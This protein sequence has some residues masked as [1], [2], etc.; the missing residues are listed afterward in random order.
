MDYINKKN[1]T[2]NETLALAFENHKKNN[3]KAA[4]N[5]Y[6]KILN[7][8]PNHFESNFF[9]GTLLTQSRRFD[10]AQKLLAKA[11]QIKPDHADAHNNLGSV[12]KGLGKIQE[13]KI[14]FQKS[15]QIN[16]EAADVHYNLGVVFK[17][18]G[19]DMEA[20]ACYQKAI[21]KDH[22]HTVSLINLSELLKT[23]ELKMTTGTN[24]DHLKDLFLLLFRRNDVRHRDIF[25]KTRMLLKSEKN[26]HKIW[27]EIDLNSL[28]FKNK[29]IKNLL[30]EELFLLMLQK[31]LIADNFLEKILTKLRSDALFSFIDSDKN[32][33][34]ENL[35]FI[36]SLAEQCFL[37]EYVYTQTA[38]E[39]NFINQLKN[40]VENNTKINEMEII[41]LGCYIP[42]Y[43]SSGITNRL[44]NYKSKNTLFNDL[45]TM[46]IIEPLKE[47]KLVNSI[48]SFGE[49]SNVISKKV[50]DQYEKHPYP[51]WR[52]TY[53]NVRNNFLFFLN[54][55]IK[56]NK[57]LVKNKFTNPNVLVAGCGTGNHM[58][59]VENYSNANILAVDLSL[60]SLAYSKRKAEELGFK[61]IE[62]L[63]ADILQL[64]NI[65]R[66]FDV[67]E[68]VGVLHH[69]ED[70]VMGL[71]ILL[72]LLEPHGFLKIGLYSKRA[73]QEVIKVKE[74]IQKNKFKNT[75]D[76]IKISRQAIIKQNKN[77]E[78]KNILGT[79]D[80]YSTSMVKDLLFHAQEHQFTL[81]QISKILKNLNLEFLGFDNLR[82]K[83]KYS[84]L[85]PN[86]KNNTSLDNWNQF[87]TSNPYSFP[88]MYS[89]W[90]R[91]M[92]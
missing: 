16:P 26:F 12:L 62:F 50:R 19:K 17:S 61:N 11:I 47:Q 81:P 75:I 18:L 24:N 86:D 72:N 15:I 43:S 10:R 73:R 25:F 74:F 34:E 66:K 84:K 68:C 52:Y 92:T 8:N 78:L 31:T 23:A 2:I 35:K 7:T 76:D 33:L 67:I 82:I 3:L 63:H 91:K 39:T 46:Q 88:G 90:V 44:S 38:K 5:L 28:S 22:K 71:K 6:T 59:F 57:I 1:L 29:I 41:I 32:I 70:P 87:E 83:N 65:N 58:C 40:K 79:N 51:R 49:I 77:L 36:T 13:A 55:Q 45:I 21:L 69:M 89:F 48:K 9:L 4:E 85:F 14:C 60:A 80:F 64:S 54:N 37:N 56:P 42:L 20:I 53:A 27:E 30:K